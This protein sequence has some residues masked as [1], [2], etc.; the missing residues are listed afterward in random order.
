M[1]QAYDYWQDQPGIYRARR[2]Q[3][4]FLRH[5]AVVGIR[6]S[7]PPSSRQRRPYSD[8]VIA[9]TTL[10]PKFTGG[11]FSSG[12]NRF[13]E[14]Y[15]DYRLTARR[16]ILLAFRSPVTGPKTRTRSS[17]VHT[18]TLQPLTDTV[19]PDVVKRALSFNRFERSFT[20]IA[21]PDALLVNNEPLLGLATAFVCLCEEIA[22]AGKSGG[23]CNS[24]TLVVITNAAQLTRHSNRSAF[25]HIKCTSVF[26]SFPSPV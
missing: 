24:E 13:V 6:P 26:Y 20:F 14:T 12:I 5:A 10:A 2:R 21:L 18:S 9:Q 17:I 4:P 22:L 15:F 16:F 7:A 25:S 3:L 23:F 8:S 1:R 11:E 19:A